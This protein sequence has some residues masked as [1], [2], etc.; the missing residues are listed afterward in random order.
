MASSA[1]RR[2]TQGEGGRNVVLEV[3]CAVTATTAE[4]ASTA[5]R[6]RLATACDAAARLLRARGAIA[7]AAGALE[8]LRSQ[9]DV[10]EGVCGRSGGTNDAGFS[11]TK[12]W[13]T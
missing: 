1:S 9:T 12:R 13:I 8:R 7:R 5:S 2:Y 10:L 3:P 11:G 6:A 4:V